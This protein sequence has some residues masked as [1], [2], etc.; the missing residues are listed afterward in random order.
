MVAV[1][2][3]AADVAQTALDTIKNTTDEHSPSKATEE[4]GVFLDLGLANG[5]DKAISSVTDSATNLGAT[6]VDSV[7]GMLNG[8][9]LGTTGIAA[10]ITPVMDLSNVRSSSA[11]LGAMMSR[12]QALSA[13]ASFNLN[14]QNDDIAT[15]VKIGSQLLKSVQNGSDLYLDERVLVGRINRRLGQL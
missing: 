1:A 12:N 2:K 13:S 3:A 4:M 14:A 9:D 7:Q 5:I 6:A 11:Q 10:A 15:L 8:F